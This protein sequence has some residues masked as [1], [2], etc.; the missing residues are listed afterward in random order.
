MAD[1]QTDRWMESQTDTFD[2]S[3]PVYEAKGKQTR[4]LNKVNSDT[5][6]TKTNT[7]AR[8]HNTHKLFRLLMK[9]IKLL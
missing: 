3:T 8:T 7:R 4:T 5:V 1:R 6:K 9:L 2:T